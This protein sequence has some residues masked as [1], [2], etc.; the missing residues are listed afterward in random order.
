MTTEI[1]T[2]VTSY[3][4]LCVRVTGYQPEGAALVA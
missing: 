2:P 1:K 3:L 4:H